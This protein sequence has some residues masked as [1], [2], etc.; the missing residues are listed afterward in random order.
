VLLLVTIGLVVVGAVALVIG[1]VSNSLGPIYL[2]IACSVIAGIVL[3]VFSRMARRQESSTATAGGPSTPSRPSSWGPPTAPSAP[4]SSPAAT[5]VDIPATPPPPPPVSRA[6][7]SRQEPAFEPEPAYAPEPEPAAATGRFAAREPEPEPMP[8]DDGFPIPGY[9]SMRAS[10][11]LER[12]PELRLEELDMVREREEQ[13]KNRATIIRRVDLRIDELEAAEDEALAADDLAEPEPQ[14][15]EPA[16]VAASSGG[17]DDDF[18]IEDYDQLSAGEIIAMLDD[19]DDDELDMV[20]AREERGLNRVE[21]LEY[22]DDMFEEVPV[23]EA[24]A[25][26][27]SCS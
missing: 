16:P 17:D 8:E 11:I 22:I 20:A 15:A 21:I 7:P 10:Q 5:R 18:P 23:D 19:L 6:E 12:L 14:A 13:G 24:A 1:F 26:A 2:S 9:D 3:V 27:D 25:P 4:S